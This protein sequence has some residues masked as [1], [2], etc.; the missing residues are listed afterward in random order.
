MWY[1][2]SPEKSDS[3]TEVCK[4]FQTQKGLAAERKDMEMIKQLYLDL[5]CHNRYLLN[6]VEMKLRLNRLKDTFCIFGWQWG[7]QD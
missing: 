6:K 3:L 1:E 7:V 4:D 5:C 2:D